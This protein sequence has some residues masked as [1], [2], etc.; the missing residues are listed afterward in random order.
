[1][2]GMCPDV[3]DGCSEIECGALPP[4]REDGTRR[5]YYIRWFTLDDVFCKHL[6]EQYGTSNPSLAD[7]VQREHYWD[8]NDWIPEGADPLVCDDECV[9]KG[10]WTVME[11][12]N[13]INALRAQECT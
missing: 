3:V 8:E 5:F 11:V 9:E 2:C 4:V 13:V 6:T 7:H 1:M 12:K 10:W